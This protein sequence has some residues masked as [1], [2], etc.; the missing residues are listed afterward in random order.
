MGTAVRVEHDFPWQVS[1]ERDALPQRTLDQIGMQ[2]VTNSAPENPASVTIAHDAQIGPS[3]TG[4]QI[5]DIGEPCEVPL[6]LVKLPLDKKRVPAV[7]GARRTPRA[8]N[9]PRDPADL[10]EFRDYLA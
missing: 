1:A 4:T 9:D 8:R 6:A 7:N 2:A 3:S 5:G 10:H